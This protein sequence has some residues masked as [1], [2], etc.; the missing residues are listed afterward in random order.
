[1][2]AVA[3]LVSSRDLLV[4]LTLREIRGKYKRTALGQLWSLL[5]PIALMATYSIV[6]SILLRAK[7]DPGNP[8]GL[9]YFF[10]WLSCA[11]LPWVFIN[12]VLTTG[13]G[14]IIAN[15]N[16]VLKVYFPRE[17]LV[18]ANSLSW[19]FSFS[20]E[21]VVVVAAT[22]AFGGRPLLYLPATILLMLFA[23]LMATGLAF[24]LAVANVYFRDTQHFISI[25]LNL[26]FYAA[27][28]VY[29]LKLVQVETHRHPILVRVVEWNPV[30][31]FAEGFRNAIYDGRWPTANNLLYLFVISTVV[32]V[33][34][35]AF[36]R[37]NTGRL[38]EEL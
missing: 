22:L 38:A 32:F 36:F 4:N 16:L 14:T 17:V 12:N 31:H 13:M 8:S 34:G 3:D 6:F 11:L 35:Y 20:I 21:M 1:M 25:A 2:S 19:L 24:F 15:S 5:N 33:A 7:P 18:I 10:L 26:L 30:T 9:N 37:H 23:A 28:I 29:P 27:P